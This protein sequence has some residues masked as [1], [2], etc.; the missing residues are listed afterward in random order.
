MALVRSVW[1][2]Y[3]ITLGGALRSVEWDGAGRMS[4]PAGYLMVKNDATYLYTALDMVADRGRDP[5][6]GD[7]FWFT[8]DVNS[9]RQI[10]PMIDTNYGL[11][12]GHQVRCSGFLN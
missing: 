1:A 2:D 7:Y 3:R 10:T 4:I 9:N 8:V 6:T 12:P 5:G 11:Y